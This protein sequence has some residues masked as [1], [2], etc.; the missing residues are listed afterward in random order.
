M[1]NLYIIKIGGSVLTKKDARGIHIR[2]SLILSIAENINKITSK[3]KDVQLILIHG[4]GSVGHRLAKKYNLADGVNGN[5]EKWHGALKVR[6]GI[7]DL[8]FMIFQSFINNHINISPIHTS[9]VIIQNNKSIKKFNLDTVKTSLKN[10]CIPMLYGDMVFDEKLDMSVCSGDTIAAHLS[11]KL[12]IKKI[13]FASD[14]GGIFEKD[15]HIH[16]D[17]KLIEKVT[18]EEI[19]SS[20][21]IDLSESHSTDVTGGLFGKVSAFKKAVN[22][23]NSLEEIIIFNGLKGENYSKVF[24]NK[25]NLKT[26][27]KIK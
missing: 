2:H 8:N 22:K 10:N 20:K 9:S 12:N 4:A 1:D 6:A 7:Q 19:F 26:S 24:N 14:I 3:H 16:K 15:P 21:K 23:N 27:I 13:F 18:F 25:L 11:E 17:A 5:L